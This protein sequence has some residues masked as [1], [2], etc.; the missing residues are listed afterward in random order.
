MKKSS[1]PLIIIIASLLVLI[2]IVVLI[3]QG[4]RL[5]YEELQR[6]F[7]QLES[8]I[9]TEKNISVTNKA[10]F[11]MLTAEDVIEKFAINELGLVEDSN[12]NDRK[13]FLSGEEIA[14]VSKAVENANE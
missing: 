10:N 9:K 12:V 13:I 2:T 1:K 11:Q 5:K 3:A 7:A 8:S 14:I 4:L 6:E